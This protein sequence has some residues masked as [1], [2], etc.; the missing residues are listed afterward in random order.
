L[1]VRCHVFVCSNYRF[2]LELSILSHPMIS[3]LDFGTVW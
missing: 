3:L 2:V 1:C